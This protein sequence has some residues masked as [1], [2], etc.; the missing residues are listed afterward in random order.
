MNVNLSHSYHQSGAYLNEPSSHISCQV[1]LPDHDEPLK[2]PALIDANHLQKQHVGSLHRL[3]G[4]KEEVDEAEAHRQRLL[5][6]IARL[7]GEVLARVQGQIIS[8]LDAVEEEE[9][10]GDEELK[11]QVVGED[12]NESVIIVNKDSVS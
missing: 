3:P 10:K 9:V 8:L 2:P 7:S 11:Q 6:R 5:D 12:K 4:G 1:F